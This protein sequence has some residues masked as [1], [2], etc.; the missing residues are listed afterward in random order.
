MRNSP[1]DE[2]SLEARVPNRFGASLTSDADL[3][4]A[5][6]EWL[7]RHIRKRYARGGTYPTLTDTQEFPARGSDDGDRTKNDQFSPWQPREV[8]SA[9][10]QR[11]ATRIRGKSVSKTGD[12]IRSAGIPCA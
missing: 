1:L 2:D 3:L 8:Q 9:R 6:L 5:T 4:L 7:R 12:R 11:T 10:V